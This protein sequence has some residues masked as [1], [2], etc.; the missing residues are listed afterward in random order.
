M[1]S[2]ASEFV[3]V[4]VGESAIVLE[5]LLLKGHNEFRELRRN[6]QEFF[7]LRFTAV[8]RDFAAVETVPLD[9]EKKAADCCVESRERRA[10]CLSQQL[11]C[12]PEFFLKGL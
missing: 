3:L 11:P 7:P 5:T 6:P 8:R 12:F 9:F 10:N 4:N 1:V 2:F